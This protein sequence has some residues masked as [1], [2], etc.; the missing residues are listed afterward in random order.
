VLP[1]RSVAG[2]KNS[3]RLK[4]EVQPRRSVADRKPKTGLFGADSGRIRGH[5]AER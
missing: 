3:S 1:R 4:R 2:R 5:D